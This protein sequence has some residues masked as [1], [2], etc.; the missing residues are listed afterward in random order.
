M[1]DLTFQINAGLSP[2][3]MEEL[4][5]G[6]SLG[7]TFYAECYD[8]DGNLRWKDTA[9]NILPTINL[10]DVLNVYFNASS[11]T[12]VWYMMMVD[13]AGF[14]AFSATDTAAS[15]SGWSENTN[16][17]L[18][19]RPAWT[20]GAASAGSMSNPSATQFNMNPSTTCTLKG[21]ALISNNTLGGTSG[22]LS[23]E[24]ALGTPQ[25][26]NNGDTLKVTYAINATTS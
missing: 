15:H 24:A 5:S 7:G 20:P 4:A 18:A 14:S 2:F 19:S 26:C 16:T 9:K 25:L 22:M 3:S 11:Q 12:T 21:F 8:K 6:F 23:A 10:N 13:N 17:S 1:D